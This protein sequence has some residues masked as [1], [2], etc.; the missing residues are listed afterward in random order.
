VAGGKARDLKEGVGLAGES[1]D[2]HAAARKLDALVTFSRQL[3][4]ETAV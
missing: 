3:S 4:A 2:S 1:I